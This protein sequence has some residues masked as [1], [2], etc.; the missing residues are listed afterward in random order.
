MSE[1]THLRTGEGSLVDAPP[2]FVK[3]CFVIVDP[4]VATSLGLERSGGPRLDTKSIRNAQQ[5]R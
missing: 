4:L 1:V 2:I 3:F 5:P